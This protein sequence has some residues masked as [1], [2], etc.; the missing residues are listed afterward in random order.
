MPEPPPHIT[1]ARHDRYGVVA[2]ASHHNPV[3]AH[4]LRRVGFHPLPDR[5]L[6][7]LTE[8]HRDTTRRSQQ[9]VQSLRAAHYNVTADSAYDVTASKSPRLLT[10]TSTWD[11]AQARRPCPD[12][13]LAFR[14]AVAH[15]ATA[16]SPAHAHVHVPG[17]QRP[18][19]SPEYRLAPAPRS[20]ARAR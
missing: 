14:Q 19:V 17:P 20:P 18:A 12:P 1:I 7:A 16:A 13:R 9:A 15:A 8:P 6:Y 10:D 11:D 4:M 5:D 2:S 3:A